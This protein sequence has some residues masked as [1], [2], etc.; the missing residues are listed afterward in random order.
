MPG[1]NRVSGGQRGELFVRNRLGHLVS[2][3][4]RCRAGL[5]ACRDS[6]PRG[7]G[8]KACTTTARVRRS[9]VYGNSR[10]RTGRV[11]VTGPGVWP[12]RENRA[13]RRLSAS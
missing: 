6:D 2:S 7:A 13:S 9:S 10:L 11:A 3:I 5:Q 8:L 12:S 1:R 4:G